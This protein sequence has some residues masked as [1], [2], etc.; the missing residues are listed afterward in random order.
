MW[1]RISLRAKRDRVIGNSLGSCSKI[2]GSNPIPVKNFNMKNDNKKNLIKSNSFFLN[3]ALVKNFKLTQ[4]LKLN[5]KSVK[6]L[7]L[8][9]TQA[10]RFWAYTSYYKSL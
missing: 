3:Y 5:S 8:A 2:I 4:N 7:E 10:L 1:V 6:N 9:S